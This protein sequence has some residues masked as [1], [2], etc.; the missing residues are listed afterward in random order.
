MDVAI[1]DNGINLID[2][3]EQY[4]IPSNARSPEGAVETVIGNWLKQSPGRRE[5][6]II[7]YG[8]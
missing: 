5:K 8:C 7:L 4:P 1:L 3:A 6:V 2:T